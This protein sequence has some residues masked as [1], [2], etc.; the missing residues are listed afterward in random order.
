[1]CHQDWSDTDPRASAEPVA[2]AVEDGDP[3]PAWEFTPAA[4]PVGTCVV[5]PDIFGPV[6]FYAQVARRLADSGLRAVLVDYFFRE[7]P[8][9]ELT[10]E[11][12][13]A[14]RAALD[15]RRTIRDLSAAVDQVRSDHARTGVIGFCLAG[16]LAL[17]LCAERD[18]L[19]A[20]C[21]YPFPEGV[22]GPVAVRAPRPIDLAAR[23]KGPVVSFWGS[24]DY[25]GRDVMDRFERAMHAAGADYRQH[26][27]PGAT[28]GF[29]RG[30]VEP[31][32]P[33]RDA[34][35]DAWERSVAFL[36]SALTAATQEAGPAR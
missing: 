2:V 14:R 21:F 32:H 15:E 9:T 8:L 29:L 25:V 1:M 27:Y 7:G 20:V 4:A 10:R 6:P 36:A 28:H 22:A 26:I 31:D 35:H 23:I 19:A 16:Q 5:V 3:M 34:A 11:A 17:D 13:F 30:L 18:D 24:E 12:A 33:D